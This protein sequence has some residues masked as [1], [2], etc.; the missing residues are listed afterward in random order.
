V[1]HRGSGAFCYSFAPL[2]QAPPG[3]PSVPTVSGKGE[4]HRVTVVGP[5]VTPDVQWEG[6]ALGPYD[7]NADAALNALFD[8][9]LGADSACRTE[10]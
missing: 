2:A 6:P 4:R 9:I 3:Y 7:E 1:T 8:S 10:R 5:G